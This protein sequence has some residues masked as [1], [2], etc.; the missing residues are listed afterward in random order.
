[1]A[2]QQPVHVVVLHGG[3]PPHDEPADAS[4]PTTNPVITQ[5]IIVIDMVEQLPGAPSSANEATARLSPVPET[6]L[7]LQMISLFAPP[8]DVCRMVGTDASGRTRG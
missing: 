4:I 5:R 6:G 8:S 2:S 1:M 7:L 3:C